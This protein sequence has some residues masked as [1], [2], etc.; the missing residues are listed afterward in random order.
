MCVVL[1]VVIPATNFAPPVAVNPEICK[2]IDGLDASLEFEAI[3]IR[4][5]ETVQHG[6]R[7][8]ELLEEMASQAKARRNRGRHPLR[9]AQARRGWRGHGPVNKPQLLRLVLAHQA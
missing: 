7:S 8:C 1:L 3:V 4:S 6:S 9:V 2:S 5:I